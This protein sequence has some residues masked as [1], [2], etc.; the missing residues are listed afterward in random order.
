MFYSPASLSSI[1]QAEIALEN[2]LPA[3]LR[4][5]LAATDGVNQRM[6]I[7][8]GTVEIGYLIWPIEWISRENRKF[9]ANSLFKSL[10]RPFDHLLFFADAG[11]GDHFGFDLSEPGSKSD[12]LA[13]DHEDDGRKWVAPSLRVF[14]EWWSAGKIIV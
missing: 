7:A 11:N 1:R 10:Y 4:E 8:Q 3:E 9:R 12:I 5:L 14:I 13:W 2:P 6:R